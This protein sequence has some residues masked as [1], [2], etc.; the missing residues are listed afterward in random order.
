MFEIKD[1]F[2]LL[3]KQKLEELENRGFSLNSAVGISAPNSSDICDWF[4]VFYNK[5]D[6]LVV[7][8][9][10]CSSASDVVFSEPSTP[11][12][13]LQWNALDLKK[14]TVKAS[15]I[16]HKA[17]PE[18]QKFKQSLSQVIIILNSEMW[19][20]QFVTKSLNVIAVSFDAVSGNMMHTTHQSLVKEAK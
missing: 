5:N 4:F 2:K 16:I 3:P 10:T 14:I 17:L 9:K 12:S 7:S 8:A 13:N 19:R 11:N 6:N 18:F 1:T 20:V 15:T